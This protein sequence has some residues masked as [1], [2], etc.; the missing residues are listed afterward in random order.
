MIL[1]NICGS[2]SMPDG[3]SKIEI[4]LICEIHVPNIE[5]HCN[6]AKSTA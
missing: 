1:I 3:P 4:H 5:I 6:W 2:V